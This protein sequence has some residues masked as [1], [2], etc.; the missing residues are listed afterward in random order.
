MT[1]Y[2]TSLFQAF[3]KAPFSRLDRKTSLMRKFFSV[4]AS[5]KR[6]IGFKSPPGGHC[7]DDDNG[8]N[9]MNNNK[10]VYG[11]HLLLRDQN[12]CSHFTAAKWQ[13]LA[14][15]ASLVFCYAEKVTG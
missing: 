14:L 2:P 15:R 12:C 7:H 9:K 3:L 1:I 11:W 5:C 13:K 10:T 6:G 8:N 4:L